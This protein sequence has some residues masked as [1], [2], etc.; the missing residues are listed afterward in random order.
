MSWLWAARRAFE[1]MDTSHRLKRALLASVR[2]HAHEQGIVNGEVVYV[3]RKVKKSRTDARTALVTDGW[4][5]P[6]I[7]VGQEKN[8]LFVSYR[9]GL[10]KVAPECL[11]KASVAEQMRWDM[12]NE[13]ALDGE[14]PS[15]E[16]PMLGES[17]GSLHRERPDMAAEPPTFDREDSPPVIDDDDGSPVSEAPI[18]DDEDPNE[19]ERQVQEPDLVTE[20]SREIESDQLRRRLTTKQSR[21]LGR[22]LELSPEEKK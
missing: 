5:G 4:Y 15:W 11:R 3:W 20:E 22:V 18:D 2:A 1:T 12:F 14:G 9:G 17:G 21:K 10:T 6:A 8:N 16:E 19:G 7:V 13:G